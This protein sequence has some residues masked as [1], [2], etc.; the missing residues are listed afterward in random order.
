MDFGYKPQY[1]LE[2][3]HPEMEAR[4]AALRA[5]RQPDADRIRDQMYAKA[6]ADQRRA[7]E[8]NQGWLGLKGKLMPAQPPEFHRYVNSRAAEIQGAQRDSEARRMR[9]LQVQLL[10]GR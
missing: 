7:L 3:M 5:G 2:A 1:P 8:H 9:E 6:E 10:R 4:I